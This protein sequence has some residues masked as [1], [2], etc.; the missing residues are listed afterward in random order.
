MSKFLTITDLQNNIK[1]KEKQTKKVF[2]EVLLD[3]YAKIKKRNNFN[4]S[5]NSNPYII[6][7]VPPLIV[8]QP[9]YNYEDLL[10][11]LIKQL[12][13]GGFNVLINKEHGVNLYISWDL[14][15][16]ETKN[17]TKK[18]TKKVTFAKEEEIKPIE[19]IE[20]KINIGKL[21]KKELEYKVESFMRTNDYDLNYIYNK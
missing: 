7:K 21:N 15:K 16:Q 12:Q 4:E 18:V 9:L 14:K 11:Y 19:T 20:T 6:F 5:L 1:E 10:K 3:C 13:K 2:K 17:P 8:G